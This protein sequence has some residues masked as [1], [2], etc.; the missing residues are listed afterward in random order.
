MN[1]IVRVVTGARLHF[2]FLAGAEPSSVSPAN[3]LP[4]G[5]WRSVRT[6]GGVG[7]MVDSPSVRLSVETS[8]ESVEINR[9]DAT[10]ASRD[11]GATGD[12]AVRPEGCRDASASDYVAAEI[13]APEPWR[14]RIEAIIRRFEADEP[15]Q[16]CR[17]YRVT[18]EETIPAHMGLG[19]G[20]Q[21]ALAVAAAI[22]HLQDKPLDPV[23][24]AQRAGRGLRS[25]VGLY[26]FL[27]GGLIVDAGKRP[28][29][30]LSPMLVRMAVPRSWS[31][32]GPTRAGG[33]SGTEEQNA[34]DRLPPMPA[35]L[36][37]RLSQLALTG[38][39]P[40]IVE[41]NYS[42]FG[43]ALF[44]FNRLV[45]RYFIPVQGGEYTSEMAAEWVQFAR[46][47]GIPAVGQSSWGPTLFAI[48]PDNQT[49]R[50]LAAATRDDR[51]WRG[52][53]VALTTPRNAPAD[54]LTI[55]N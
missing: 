36:T 41:A 24:L 42:E 52:W 50:R 22:A 3:P 54:V 37:A 47:R 31:V 2:G 33:L 9:R 34:F 27:H 6:F 5:A 40:A 25:A 28:E 20:T 1:R 45:G 29:E 39:L 55:E 46:N 4:D 48:C 26:G 7:M 35:E 51:R 18:L 17:A 16:H 15:Q 21:L 32:V 11:T 8:N 12:N 13:V 44:E 14:K 38:L 23:R 53:I 49:A 19:S 43:E 30:P 10:E